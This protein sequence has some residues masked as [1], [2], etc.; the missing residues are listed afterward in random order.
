[1]VTLVWISLYMCHVVTRLPSPGFLVW[2]DHQD[3]P[4]ISDEENEV[5]PAVKRFLTDQSWKLSLN[6]R[7]SLG[8]GHGNGHVLWTRQLFQLPR[9]L[10]PDAAI[11]AFPGSAPAE[12]LGAWSL[13]TSADL[14]L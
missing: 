1:M 4:S 9:S 3:P 5:L 2:A 11:L 10:P 6:P 8:P 13:G 14:V 7:D 12:H